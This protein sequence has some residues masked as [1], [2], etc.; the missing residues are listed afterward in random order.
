MVGDYFIYVKTPDMNRFAALDVGSGCTVN[1]IL[2]ASIIPSD[3]A[4]ELLTK[5]KSEYPE[6]Q[7]KLKKIK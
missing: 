4:Q 6:Y 7:F 5:L 2:F 1:K 3:K